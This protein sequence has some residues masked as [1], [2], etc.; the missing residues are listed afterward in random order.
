MGTA[1]GQESFCPFGSSY[2]FYY[3]AKLAGVALGS[4]RVHARV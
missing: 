2:L 1:E 4:W 3:H